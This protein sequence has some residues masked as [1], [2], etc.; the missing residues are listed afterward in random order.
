MEVQLLKFVQMMSK[1]SCLC[2]F[3]ICT[4][5]MFLN[6]W[7]GLINRLLSNE[8]YNEI[9]SYIYEYISTYLPTFSVN[10]TREFKDQ[11]GMV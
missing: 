5:C 3:Y 9:H 10:P 1:F 4:P 2:V 6:I 7:V 8:T 11:I